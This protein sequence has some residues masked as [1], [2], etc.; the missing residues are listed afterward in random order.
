MDEGF[1]RALGRRADSPER[2]A[3]LAAASGVEDPLGRITAALAQLRDLLEHS[4]AERWMGKYRRL[5]GRWSAGAGE[6]AAMNLYAGPATDESHDFCS[7]RCC[8]R[9]QAEA[10]LLAV[11]AA[12]YLPGRETAARTEGLV[13]ST[14]PDG[15]SGAEGRWRRWRAASAGAAASDP[16][17]GVYFCLWDYGGVWM[18][19][20]PASSTASGK[21][22]GSNR[23]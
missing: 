14:G 13:Y 3:L 10:C 5:S 16:T 18:P 9:V 2:D 4:V 1:L 15:G 22:L 17:V 7:A 19:A 21:C 23:F 6:N 12:L 8:M 11:L 20:F